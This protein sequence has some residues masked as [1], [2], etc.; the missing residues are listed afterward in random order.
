MKLQFDYLE[1][2]PFKSFLEKQTLHFSEFGSGVHFV[3]GVNRVEPRLGSNG[4]G[5]SSL[6]DALVWCLFG[7][8]VHGLQGPDV[9]PWGKDTVV[10]EVGFSCNGNPHDIRRTIKP[11][12]TTLDGKETN[13]DEIDR[14]LGMH[15]DTFLH[16]IVMGQSMPLFF[17]LAPRDKM[18]LL[19]TVLRLDRWDDRADK[20]ADKAKLLALEVAKIERERAGAK[21]SIAELGELLA[22][23]KT[24]VEQW[25]KA[26]QKLLTETDR[27]IRKI[28]GDLDRAELSLNDVDLELDGAETELRALATQFEK[29]SLELDKANLAYV[30]ADEADK[31]NRSACLELKNKMAALGESDKCDMCGQS[32]RGTSLEKH[33]KQLKEALGKREAVVKKGIDAKVCEAVDDAQALVTRTRADLLEFKRKADAAR[34][35][36]LTRTSRVMEL[37]GTLSGAKTALARIEGEDNPH[38][39][40]STAMRKRLVLIKSEA[41]D[42][43]EDWTAWTAKFERTKYWVKGFR[44]VR[45]HLLSEFMQ[46]LEVATNSMIDEVGLYGW[47]VRFDIEKE[48]KAGT[49]KRGLS[50]EIYK[51]GFKAPCRWESYS[52]GEGQRL[53]LISALAL[54]EVLLRHA[55]VL[56]DMEVLDE[57]TRHLSTAGVRDLADYLCQ[58]AYDQRK[59]IWLVDHQAIESAKFRSGLAIERG[60]HGARIVRE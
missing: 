19:S 16:T 4:A 43:E 28:N 60:K 25:E 48:T 40:A 38:Q 1:V 9:K 46:E 15:Y 56:C 54:S 3:S 50:T 36:V 57:P 2:G 12:L 5:K 18:E 33:R 44:D 34:D 21:Q 45:L 35:L 47:E 53:R 58:R 32:L 17:D 24:D 29:A 8:T 22:S 20:A 7:R 26:R 37:K 23:L 13:Q 39:I 14:I 49:L 51:P 30:Q 27:E 42:I 52:G 31:S 10:V 59:S 55:G 11:N 41:K 6:W